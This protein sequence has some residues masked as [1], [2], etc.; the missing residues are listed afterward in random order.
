MEREGEGPASC[1]NARYYVLPREP[2]IEGTIDR[3]FDRQRGDVSIAYGVPVYRDGFSSFSS[4][5]EWSIE[6]SEKNWRNANRFKA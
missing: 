3:S 4:H 6:W 1:G 5:G 2:A